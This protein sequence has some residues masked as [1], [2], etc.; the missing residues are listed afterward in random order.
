M[1]RKSALTLRRL[2][3]QALEALNDLTDGGGAGAGGNPPHVIS[4]SKAEPFCATGCG[5]RVIPGTSHCDDCSTSYPNGGG[6]NSGPD[7][8]WSDGTS[9]GNDPNGS[10]DGTLRYLNSGAASKGHA[11]RSSGTAD[12]KGTRFDG[13][14]I[15]YNRWYAVHDMWGTFQERMAPGVAAQI[16]STCDCRFLINHDGMPLARTIAGT[17]TLKD[18][19]SGLTCAV[20]VDEAGSQIARDL[21]SAISRGDVSQMSCGFIVAEDEWNEDYT[22]RTIKR[23][24][25]LLDVSAVTY[26]ASPTTSIGV[27]HHSA[28]LRAQRQ[29]ALDERAELVRRRQQLASGEPMTKTKT[30]QAKP[31]KID[32]Y[33]EAGKARRAAMR[34]AGVDS[35]RSLRAKLNGNR[36]VAEVR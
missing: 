22:V 15:V 35:Y 18:T 1:D 4:S 6:P 23:F 3:A 10:Q 33:Y 28:K 30:K 24:E 34:K 19:P 32:T 21:A 29:E 27:T 8:S 16:L 12:A 17:M 36:D 9:F 11:W 31:S 20:Y 14:P 25:E 7:G 2:R 26:P 5:N 13:T